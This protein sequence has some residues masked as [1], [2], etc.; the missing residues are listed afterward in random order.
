MDI[1]LCCFKTMYGRRSFKYSGVQMWN[2]LCASV[3]VTRSG[4]CA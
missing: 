1:K 2:K 4:V 3:P